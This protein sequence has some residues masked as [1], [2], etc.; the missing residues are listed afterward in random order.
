MKLVLEIRDGGD[1]RLTYHTIEKFPVVIG[2]GYQNDVIL[3]DPYVSARHMRIDYNGQDWI[4]SDLGSENGTR[5]NNAEMLSGV[6]LKS[7]DVIRLGHAEIRAFAPQH[8]VA[9]ASPLTLPHPGLD[10]L[11]RSGAAWVCFLLAITVTQGWTY[12]EIW[13][14]EVRL[15]LATAAAGV[16]ATMIVWAAIW[17]VAGRLI[18]SR[19]SFRGHSALMA[20]YLIAGAFAWYIEAYAD[21]LLNENQLAVA[22]T[23]GINFVL[24]FFL[25]YG[26]LTLATRMERRQRVISGAVFSGGVVAGALILSLVSAKNFEQQPVYAGRLEPYLSGI[27]RADTPEQFMKSNAALFGSKEFLKLQDSKS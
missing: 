22:L 23:Y 8:T 15:A 21:F 4:A 1:D 25:L 6:T 19:S 7:G 14:D 5:V 12:L 20:L 18:R 16:A 3:A 27:P 11:S 24:M 13:T 17:S 10:W 26:S 9:P 2:R